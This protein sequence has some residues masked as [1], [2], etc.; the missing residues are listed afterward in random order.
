MTKYILLVLPLLAVVNELDVVSATVSWGANDIADDTTD[1]PSDVYAIDI[2]GDGDLDVVSASYYDYTIWWHENLDGSG[3]SWTTHTIS[4]ETSWCRTV[5]AQ[6]V[7]GDGDMDVLA[8][9]MS[10]NAIVWYENDGSGG[11][12]T[13]HTITS[14]ASDAYAVFAI[15]LDGD[16][17][18]D[19]LSA[20]RND[21]TVRFS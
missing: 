19:V 10:D 9:L 20:S 3:S 6:D 14:S 15:D 5:Y 12:W 13:K 11:G 4:V 8:A 1:G 2:D 21:N 18:M 17:D 16:G 7:D